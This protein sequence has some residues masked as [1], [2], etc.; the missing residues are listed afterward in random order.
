MTARFVLSIATALWL[1]GP[2]RAGA[3]DAAAPGAAVPAVATGAATPVE[4]LTKEQSDF[5]ESKVRPVLASHCYKCHSAEEKKAKGGLLLDSRQ[6]WQKGGGH[7][8][9]LVPGDPAGSLLLKAVRYE[10]A[11][12]QMP[13]N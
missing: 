1:A 11:D 7:G 9:A 3:A 8:P 10:D 6:G 2:L 4:K 5:F 12:L 13:P